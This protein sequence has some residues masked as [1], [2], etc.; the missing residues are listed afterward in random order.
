LGGV[1]TFEALGAFKA[2]GKVDITRVGNNQTGNPMVSHGRLG[3]EMHR[4]PTFPKEGKMKGSPKKGVPPL[5]LLGT[6]SIDTN[7]TQGPLGKTNITLYKYK[8]QTIK[9][10][11]L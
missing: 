9:Q 5:V 7:S 11:F 8:H 6:D 4:G 10:T 3:V 2:L 1:L